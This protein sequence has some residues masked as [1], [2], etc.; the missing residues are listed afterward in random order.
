MLG[1]CDCKLNIKIYGCRGS[2]P[3]A[4]ASDFG[5]N[6]SCLTI[7][8]GGEVLIADAGSGINNMPIPSG[9]VN[10]LIS[11]LHFDHIIGLSMFNPAWGKGNATNIY[12]CSRDGR[13]LREQVLGVFS[14]PFWPVPMD[15]YSSANVLEITPDV[16]CNIGA[17][18][19]TPFLSNHPNKTLAFHITDGKK[20]VVYL[21]DCETE[22]IDDVQRQNLKKYCTQANLV[23]FDATYSEDD[24]DRHVGWGHSTVAQG[25]KLAHEFSCEAMLF[26][27][28]AQ[29]YDDSEIRSWERNFPTDGAIKFMLAF[30]GMEICI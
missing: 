18:T 28:F 30:D 2:T 16:P 5:G 20:T 10:I 7:E 14:P 21:L 13:P 8:S 6:T 26:S 27:H 25:I 1:R 29:N 11:H 23:V 24:Y 3:V 12:S 17:F 19:V 15:K 4:Q 9:E 22:A